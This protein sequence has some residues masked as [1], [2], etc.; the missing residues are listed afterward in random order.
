M[1]LKKVRIENFRSFCDQTVE[2]DDNTCLVGPNGSGKSAVLTALNVFFRH[3]LSTATNVHRLSDEDFHH[4]K[5]GLPVKIT[6]TFEGLS[7][8]AQVDFRHYYRQGQLV[9]FAKA[10]WDGEGADV[11]QHGS[12]RVMKALAAYFE[13]HNAKK[14]VEELREIYAQIRKQFPDLPKAVS[15]EDMTTALRSLEEAHPE[16]CELIDEPNEFYGWTKGS[17]LLEKHVQWV[18]VPAVKDAVTEQEEGTKTALG[19][20][21]HRTIRAQV[22]FE[23]PLS[24]LKKDLESRYRKIIDSKQSALDD[25]QASIEGRLQELTTQAARLRLQWWYD[26]EKSLMVNEPNARVSLGEDSFIGE[27][28]RLGH[29]MQRAFLLSILQ[30]LATRRTDTAPT[31]LLGFEEPELYQHPPQA[32]HIA[33]LLGRLAE[34][35]S[36][37]TQVLVTTHSPYFVPAR[38]FESVRMVRKGRGDGASRVTRAT[39]HQVEGALAEAL[40]EKPRCP[41]VLMAAVEQILQ[42]SQRELFFASVPVIVEGPEDVAFISTHMHLNRKWS[43]FRKLGCH[44]VVAEGKTNLSRLL[45]IANQLT[46]PAFVVFDAD[47]NQTKEDERRR[48]RRD[49][50][51]IL[52]LCGHGGADPLPSESLWSSNAVMWDTKILEVVRQSLGQSDWETAVE[53]AKEEKDFHGVKTKNPLLIAATLEEL[54]RQGKRS[55]ILDKLTDSILLFATQASS[56]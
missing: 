26:P 49:N 44:F 25:L 46:I 45:A 22:D 9:V 5:T 24:A 48:N 18:Y 28:P 39:Y 35:P 53:K 50:S 42:P 43:D 19:Q 8:E 27:V 10:E 7:K 23:E 30:E 33:D 37:R 56:R 38:G 34:D 12:R 1:R 13:A 11:K 41:S 31:L 20:L 16:H 14:K 2:M 17:N 15:K 52:R 36:K 54:H 29:G 6:L 4:R 51:C 21:L 40:G 3:S 55:S 32:Q 47:V